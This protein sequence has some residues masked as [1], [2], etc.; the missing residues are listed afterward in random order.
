MRILNVG[1]GGSRI[2]T[3]KW[4]NLDDLHSQLPPGSPARNALDSEPNY[5]NFVLLSE[6]MPYPDGEFNGV[7]LSHVLEHFDAQQG[8]QLLKDCRRVLMPEGIIVVSVPNATY[9]RNVSKL[10]RNETWPLLY[11]VSDPKNPIPTFEQAAL[12]FDQHKVIL[13]DDALWSYFDMA[14]F[15]RVLRWFDNE[16]GGTALLDEMNKALNRVPFSLVMSGV[17]G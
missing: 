7:C 11:Q 10:D 5:R 12:W 6:P 14:G 15:K 2:V 8:L 4:E 17:K 9:F 3:N 1:C 13:N 16:I